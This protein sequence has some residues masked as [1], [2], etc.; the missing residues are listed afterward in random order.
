MDKDLDHVRDEGYYKSE[1]MSGTQNY[2]YP[3]DQKVYAAS[4]YNLKL[5]KYEEVFSDK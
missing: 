2:Y 1:C 3:Q 4:Q 5:A